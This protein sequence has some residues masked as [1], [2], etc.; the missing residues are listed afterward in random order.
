V[1]G[2]GNLFGNMNVK[3]AE[4]AQPPVEEKP[5]ESDKPKDAWAMGANLINF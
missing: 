1:Q 4:V 2:G 3:M 5:K